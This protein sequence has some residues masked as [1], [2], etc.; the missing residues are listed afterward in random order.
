MDI[1]YKV[2]FFTDWHCGSGLA[3]GADADALV[4]KDSDRL[5]FLP[6]K[7]VKGLLREGMEDIITFKY[8]DNPSLRKEME[9]IV[10]E[11]LG[12]FND[13]NDIGNEKTEMKIGK[14]HFTNASLSENEREAVLAGSLQPYLFRVISSTAVSDPHLTLPTNSR[15]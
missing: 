13:S 9:E 12:F 1:E 2:E 3:A 7:T 11:T 8:G 4:I 15:V 6:G 10:K 5:P 14:A